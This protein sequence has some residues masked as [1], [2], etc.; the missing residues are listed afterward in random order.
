MIGFEEKIFIDDL[1]RLEDF[2]WLNQEII[3]AYITHIIGQNE[4]FCYITSKDI[5]TPPK[6]IRAKK[7]F[8]V[9]LDNKHFGLIIVD[10]EMKSLKIY[11]S[12]PSYPCNRQ[13]QIRETM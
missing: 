5:K 13:L 7:I 2:Q 11:D 6:N 1:L 9:Y 12:K 3:D 4:Q 8:R 10:Q